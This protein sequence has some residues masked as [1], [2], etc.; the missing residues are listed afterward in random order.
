MMEAMSCS[1]PVICSE[2]R[3]NTD[4][5][6]DTCGVLCSATDVDAFADAIEKLISDETLR[7]SM[8]QKAKDESKKYDIKIIE[9]YMK[10]IYSGE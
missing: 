2:I 3:G 6:D 8:A 10:D 5:I 7:K 9:N 4:L 1:L